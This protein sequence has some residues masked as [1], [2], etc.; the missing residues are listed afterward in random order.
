MCNTINLLQDFRDI[1]GQHNITI[2]DGTKLLVKKI[3]NVLLKEG[4][5]LKNVLFVPDM[6]YILISYLSTS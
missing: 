2:P 4:L 5:M 3:G 6:K 1:E